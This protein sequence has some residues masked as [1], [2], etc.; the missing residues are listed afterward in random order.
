[1]VEEALDD[2][3]PGERHRIYRLLGLNLYAR[4]DWSLEITGMF[5]DVAESGLSSCKP[6]P[7][8]V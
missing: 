5:A 6:S 8:S 3:V 1:M 2:L 4:H 7:L